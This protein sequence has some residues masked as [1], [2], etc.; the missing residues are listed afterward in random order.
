MKS[1]KRTR[2]IAAVD[3]NIFSQVAA[4][5][6]RNQDYDVV[7]VH[8][9]IELEKI[10]LNPVEFPTALRKSNLEKIEKFCAGIDI[11]LKVIDVTDEVLAKVYD[12]FWM[13][14]LTGSPVNPSLDWVSGFLI[15]KLAE[16]AHDYK[17]AN[18][19]TGHLARKLDEKPAGILKYVD[20]D[21][22]MP[23]DQSATFARIPAGRSGDALEGLILP[24][25]E[26]SI[27]RLLRLAQEMGLLPKERDGEPIPESESLAALRADHDGRGR[28]KFT[29]RMLATPG[30]QERAPEGTFRRG[31]VR[32]V[33]DF[34]LA[35]HAGIP[36]FKVGDALADFPGE[37]VL[38]IRNASR[39]LIL[40]PPSALL[41]AHVFIADLVWFIP[42]KSMVRGL[43]VEVLG[44]LSREVAP[45]RLTLYPGALAELQLE[46]PLVGLDAGMILV[47]YDG[48]RVLGAGKIAEVPR[49]SGA[50]LPI[51]KPVEYE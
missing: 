33:E 49:L 43:K 26:V 20:T 5:I 25:G 42:P 47:F 29:E 17:A 51:E 32:S 24:I 46:K 27:D 15:P 31:P 1:T 9:F 22:G 4:S 16:L 50:Q 40:G 37:A 28:W 10:G 11:P 3:E 13:A 19:S 48:P 23:L 36:F 14:T 34:T 7:A 2:V 21:T 44:G 35:D 38:E 8:L 39:T 12:P 30:L 41:V 6:L 45:G 18:F